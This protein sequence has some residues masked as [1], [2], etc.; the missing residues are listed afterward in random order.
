MF[1]AL[2]FTFWPLVSCG[3]PL[4]TGKIGGIKHTIGG[5]ATD[6]VTG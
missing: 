2:L 5:R 3:V 1:I 6:G 4:K